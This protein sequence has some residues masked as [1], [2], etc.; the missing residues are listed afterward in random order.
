MTPRTPPRWVTIALTLFSVAVSVGLSVAGWGGL[1]GFLSH[2]ARRAALVVIGVLSLAVCFSRF[3]L[4]SGKREDVRNR[5]IFVPALLGTFVLCWLPAWMDRHDLWVIDGD[6]AR[7]LGVALLTAGGV[8]RIWPIFVLGRRFSGLVAIQ[9]GH[10]LVT[11]GIYR[12]V[13]H[14]SYLGAIVG[15]VGWALLFRSSVALALVP[16]FVWLLVV[17]MN[18]EEALLA[19]E[20]GPTYADYRRRSWRLV[21]GVY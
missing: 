19:S 21:P 20:F 5:I 15:F 8:L 17:R 2:P 11:T 18:S 12:H 10:A 7:W 3:N 13:R 16:G 6:A 1:A 4:S 14:P 9:E